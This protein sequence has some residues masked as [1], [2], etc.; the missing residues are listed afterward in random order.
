MQNVLAILPSSQPPADSPAGRQT[1]PAGDFQASFENSAEDG[2][3]STSDSVAVGTIAAVPSV[4]SLAAWTGLALD[5]APVEAAEGASVP[6]PNL[7]EGVGQPEEIRTGLVIQGLLAGV[8]GVRAITSEA[9]ASEPAGEGLEEAKVDLPPMPENQ[10]QGGP[11][12]N[13]GT[14]TAG[15]ADTGAGLK[16][17]A[18]FASGPGAAKDAVTVVFPGATGP[19]LPGRSPVTARTEG[20]ESVALAVATSPSLSAQS[21]PPVAPA[22]KPALRAEAQASE[23]RDRLD[24]AGATDF[25]PA[26]KGETPVDK[27]PVEDLSRPETAT[28]SERLSTATG[29]PLLVSRPAAPG[30]EAVVGATEA[31]RPRPVATASRDALPVEVTLSDADGEAAPDDTADKPRPP[32]PIPGFWERYFSG[33]QV[34]TSAAKGEQPISSPALLPQTA[35]SPLLTA[36]LPIIGTA[37]GSEDADHGTETAQDQPVTGP[38]IAAPAMAGTAPLATPATGL[39]KLPDPALGREVETERLD[40]AAL[41]GL[42]SGFPG[43]SGATTGSPVQGAAGLLVPHIAAQMTGALARAPD[44]ETELALSPDELGH[45]RLRLKPDAGN[46]DRMVVMITFERPETLD[47]FRRHAGELA[48]ALRA[49]GYSGADIGFGQRDGGT[50]GSDRREGA[51]AAP[52]SA[53]AE[54]TQPAP[55]H[56]AGASLDLRL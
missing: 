18:A 50:S 36:A 42:P 39:P 33:L 20:V 30:E 10:P 40:D 53:A 2:Q 25:R 11:G 15:G 31:G 38:G 17:L 5:P 55:R 41:A 24:P 7:G 4:L 27:S 22:D 9:T 29:L 47:L 45:V 49:A 54:P 56:L 34:A 13:T 1:E 19:E 28:D 14:D 3:A 48:E 6:S 16:G 51:A 26:P 37:L 8:P 32:G 23:A 35:P 52:R 46:P 21:S 43:A 44:G 12:T